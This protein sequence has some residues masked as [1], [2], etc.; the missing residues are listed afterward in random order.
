MEKIKLF[1][2]PSSVALV[3]A[4]DREGAVGRIVLENLLLAKDKREIYL[5]NPN[6]EKIF[7]ILELRG[8]R[9]RIEWQI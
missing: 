5:V 8:K 6:R 4:T 7:D 1:F 9:A 2:E 3:G